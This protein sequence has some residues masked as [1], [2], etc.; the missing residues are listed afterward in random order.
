MRLNVVFLGNFTVAEC[1]FVFIFHET[2][3]SVNGEHSSRL[4]SR[5]NSL[6]F[7][8][9]E[10]ATV[11]NSLHVMTSTKLTSTKLMQ[12]CICL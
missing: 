9:Y 1:F 4:F 6:M 12:V 10:R 7:T 8:W 5:Y 11:D 2:F 3:V